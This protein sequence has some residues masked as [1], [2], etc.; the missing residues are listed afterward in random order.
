MRGAFGMAGRRVNNIQHRDQTKWSL[1]SL[2]IF[3]VMGV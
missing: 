1:M 3:S 2:A